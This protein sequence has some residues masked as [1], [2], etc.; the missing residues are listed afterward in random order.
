MIPIA[1]PSVG[2]EEACA[3]SDVIRSGNL[4]SGMQVSLFEREF[5]GYIGVSHSIATSNGTT[6]LHATMLALGIGP[7]DQVLVPSF[8]FIAT[9]S[10]VTMCGASPVVTDVDDRTYC[11]DPESILEEMTSKTKAVIGVHLF[12]QPCEIQAIQ[13]ICEDHRLLFIEDCAQA[14]GARYQGENTGSF[15]AAGCFSFYPTKNM[16]TGEG[17]MIT[18]YDDDLAR[19]I[20]LIINHGQQ[21]KYLHTQIGYNFR[22]TDISAAI[23]RVQLKKLDEMNTKRQSHG[24]FYSH[25]LRKKGIFPP[26]IREGCTHVYHQ[27][28]IRIRPESGITRDELVEHLK[29]QDIGT[30]IHYPIPIHEQPVYKGRIAGSE[31]PVSQRISQEILSLPV[32]PDLTID[33]R[34]AVIT[35][36]DEVI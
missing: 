21:E 6:A 3:A 27:Y 29:E 16:T 23:G 26:V 17:G 18:C 28:A 30:A 5:S 32:Y 31:A 34:Q 25:H 35:A 7:G 14:H 22:L 1:R 20:R 9:A 24:M 15:G 36:I 19:K 11:I 4:A 13:E 33:E 12:G 2:E 10:S 8:T